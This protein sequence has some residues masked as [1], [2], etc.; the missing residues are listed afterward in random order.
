MEKLV[1]EITNF[2]QIS[3]TAK[4]NFAL[5]FLGRGWNLYQPRTKVNKIKYKITSSVNVIEETPCHQNRKSPTK[6]WNYLPIQSIRSRTENLSYETKQI[7]I[8]NYFYRKLKQ[9]VKNFSY[10][11]FSFHLL[12][13][14]IRPC[15]NTVWKL[16]M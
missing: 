14:S 7:I 3:A 1:K 11:T 5:Y 12:L 10:V 9:F 2:Q 16:R 15:Y 4:V 8:W 13:V 6:I